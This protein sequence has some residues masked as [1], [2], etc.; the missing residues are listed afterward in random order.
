MM[1]L[2]LKIMILPLWPVVVTLPPVHVTWC[3]PHALHPPSNAT[4]ARE[5]NKDHLLIVIYSSML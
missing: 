4:A 3:G 5:K 1:I 2:F